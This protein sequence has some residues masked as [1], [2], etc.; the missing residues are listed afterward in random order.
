MKKMILKVLIIATVT[1]GLAGCG[2]AS[3]SQNKDSN[4][5]FTKTYV[6]ST[7]ATYAPFEYEK[8]DKY[9]GIDIDLLASIAKLEGFKYELKAMDFKGIIPA[10]QVN[11][12]DGAIAGMGITDVRKKVLDMSEGYFESGL[13]AVGKKGNDKLKSEADFKGKIFAVKKGTLGATYAEGNKDKLGATVKYFNDTASMMQ[14]V[15]NGNADV[16]FED[17]PVIAYMISV[18]PNSGLKIIGNKLTT[19][20]YGFAVKKGSNTE[21]VTAFNDGLKKLKA[22]GEYDKIVQKYIKK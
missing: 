14:E 3:T 21:L 2:N 18:D 1:M 12:V 13:S 19:Q 20:N 17:Y 4:K 11:Q 8:D 5:K 6:I 9:I 10:L 22:N 16:T 7:D 15:K